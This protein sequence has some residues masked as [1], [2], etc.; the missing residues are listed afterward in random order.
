[1]SRHTNAVDVA[2]N[3]RI[4]ARP[5]RCR[6]SEGECWTRTGGGGGEKGKGRP[7][8]PT[9]LCC[10]PARPGAAGGDPKETAQLPRKQAGT[11]GAPPVGPGRTDP[12]APQ[13]GGH[14][15]AFS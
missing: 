5:E 8:S 1:M 10:P 9:K 12:G 7:T 14:H 2:R 6:I 4:R 13:T 3:R 15:F 11:R